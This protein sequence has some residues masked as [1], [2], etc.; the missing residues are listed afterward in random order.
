MLRIDQCKNRTFLEPG[1]LHK[2]M[3]E[4]DLENC[5]LANLPMGLWAHRE[6]LLTPT[7]AS[8][9]LSPVSHALLLL[10]IPGNSSNFSGGGHRRLFCLSLR[11]TQSYPMLFP[12]LEILLPIPG[13][14]SNC[15]GVYFFESILKAGEQG[16]GEIV[17]DV[18]DWFQTWFRRF[19]MRRGG[20]SFVLLK[21]T[22]AALVQ[23]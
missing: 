14:S 22:C 1:T 2:F 19:C 11:P 13:N 9:Q 23:H 8:A 7:K 21:Y 5:L 20:A 6:K 10:L 15:S 12:S 18:S 4:I 3:I 16:L 17:S